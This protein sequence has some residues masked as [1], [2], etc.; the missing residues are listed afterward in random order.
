MKILGSITVTSKDKIG[1]DGVAQEVLEKLPVPIT[2]IGP[3]A[4]VTGDICP[5][6]M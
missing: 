3:W 2:Q 6:I 4:H 1:S 5:R